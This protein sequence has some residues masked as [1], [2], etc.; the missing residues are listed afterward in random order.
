LEPRRLKPK[1]ITSE[2]R[3]YRQWLKKPL[4]LLLAAIAILIIIVLSIRGK[5]DKVAVKDAS[6]QEKKE[7]VTD[8]KKNVQAGRR[9]AARMAP[10]FPT[11]KQDI[12]VLVAD[13]GNVTY[14]WEKNGSVL[15]GET[16][17]RLRKDKFKK[18][19]NISVTAIADGET[20]VASVLIKNSP[21]EVKAVPF[22]P[23]A[24]YRGVDITVMPKGFD[25]DG[26]EVNFRYQWIVN[27][28]EGAWEDS[29]VLKGD[30]FKKGDAVSVRVIPYDK[31]D[32]GKIYNTKPLI[33]PNG[34]PKFTSSPPLEFKGFTYTYDAVAE[35]P[36]GD[37]VTYSVASAPKGMTIDR[38]TGNIVW[39]FTKMDE[40]SHTIE[41][42]AQD[43]EGLRGFQ[44]YTLSITIPKEEK[45]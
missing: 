9:L 42:I 24:I 27:E 23:Q 32:D 33:I 2:E 28:E 12:E 17:A 22:S 26:D 21:P 3:G 19:D 7:M 38:D 37:V 44:K 15:D 20:A 11:V 45:K 8:E 25:A 13:G 41:V 34:P 36:D 10:E 43:S 5:E 14:K 6:V 40:G 18:G 4:P 1:V 39:Q 35:D 30:R 16:S 29:P 31:E